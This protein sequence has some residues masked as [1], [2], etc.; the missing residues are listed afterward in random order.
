MTSDAPPHRVRYLVDRRHAHGGVRIGVRL[1]FRSV[2]VRAVRHVS[3]RRAGARLTTVQLNDML[4]RP[5]AYDE[6]DARCEVSR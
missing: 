4:S 3:G 2:G 5:W 1:L 6:A